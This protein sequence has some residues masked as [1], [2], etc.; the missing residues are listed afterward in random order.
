MTM[1][2]E[3]IRQMASTDII[4]FVNWRYISRV[5]SGWFGAYDLEV[6][7]NIES[8]LASEPALDPSEA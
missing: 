6:E 7:A 1:T 8:L 4:D 3:E 5:E 2:D